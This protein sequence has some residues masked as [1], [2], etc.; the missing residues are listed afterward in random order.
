MANG[1][2]A[3]GARWLL[4]PVLALTLGAGGTSAADLEAAWDAQLRGRLQQA[5]VLLESDVVPPTPA[6]RLALAGVAL[7]LGDLERAQS[8][9][10]PLVDDTGHPDYAGAAL[11]LGRLHL[12]AGR[13]EDARSAFSASLQRSADGPY[14]AAAHLALIRLD[15]HAGAFEDVGERLNRL[16]ELGPSPE[17]EMALDLL[18]PRGG[19]GPVRPFPSPLG[20]FV[21]ARLAEG[22]VPSSLPAFPS[23]RPPVDRV[24]GPSHPSGVGSGRSP[25]AGVQPVAPDGSPQTPDTA[26]GAPGAVSSAGQARPP[27][28]LVSVG[29]PTASGGPRFTLR[30]GS[31]RDRINAQHMVNALRDADLPVRTRQNGDLLQVLVGAVATRQAAQL[32]LKR[33]QEIGYDGDVIPY[34]A[35]AD[36]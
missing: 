17:L 34:R 15:V 2:A 6:H 21:A 25:Q 19:G 5:Q 23:V 18:S 35:D 30:I 7:E 16:A 12:A 22:L 1:G 32:L 36:R 13:D 24:S 3:A 14:A 26:A 31:F 29:T 33:V 28:G 10:Q 20:L 9:L 4:V 8:A 27:Q 11:L